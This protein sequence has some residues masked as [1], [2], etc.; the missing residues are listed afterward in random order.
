MTAR[1]AWIDK[2]RRME[3]AIFHPLGRELWRQA[4]TRSLMA[5]AWAGL[6]VLGL[7]RRGIRNA[8]AIAT[9]RVEI[10]FPDLAPGL[11]GLRVL[12]LSDLHLDMLPHSAPRLAKRL[13]G[14]EA[15]LA[16]IT[17][18]FRWRHRRPVSVEDLA[19][20]VTAIRAPLGLY[21]ILGNHD[22]HGLVALLEGLG[23]RVLLNESVTLTWRGA[24]LRLTGLDTVFGLPGHE[25]RA[26][27]TP[28]P[29]LFSIALVHEPQHR[30]LA[31]RQGYDLYLCG[32]THGGQICLPGERPIVTGTRF[33]RVPVAGAWEL[34]PMR[35]YTSRGAG[36]SGLP[37]RYHSQG[38]VTVITLKKA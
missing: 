29:G 35:G 32:H 6:G 26:A 5:L 2:R 20:V 12:H 22:D 33:Q 7:R 18:D 23:A 34:G 9:R 13:A 30:Q 19:R 11:D 24:A 4:T 27:L 16:V 14:I 31:A 37:V 36:V 25:A 28:A 3:A 1:Q 17:G 38:E 10:P 15:D 21:A 8:Y